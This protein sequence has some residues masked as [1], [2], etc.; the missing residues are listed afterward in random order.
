MQV[1]LDFWYLICRN[2]YQPQKLLSVNS[3]DI[4][5]LPVHSVQRDMEPE[6][7]IHEPHS[8]DQILPDNGFS[9]DMDKHAVF[10]IIAFLGMALVVL[11]ML[12]Q[13]YKGRSK[14]K[15]KRPRN[16]KKFPT[17]MMYGYKV[18]SV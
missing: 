12:N 6:V 4:G 2:L 1:M 8:P 11:F 9:H 15:H 18:P 13:Y 10:P 14:P 17:S 3:L 16:M 5:H 7:E